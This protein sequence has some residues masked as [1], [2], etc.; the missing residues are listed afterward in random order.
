M[1]SFQG[2]KRRDARYWL[3]LWL[4][5]KTGSDPKQLINIIFSLRNSVEFYLWTVCNR[6]PTSLRNQSQEERILKKNSLNQ[7]LVPLGLT[8]T[9]TVTLARNYHLDHQTVLTI[10]NKHLVLEAEMEGGRSHCCLRY[11]IHFT[12]DLFSSTKTTTVQVWTS[13]SLSNSKNVP[14]PQVPRAEGT[15]PHNR[16]RSAYG[17]STGLNT[18]QAT[19]C[20]ELHFHAAQSDPGESESDW[21]VWFHDSY[22]T[23][24]SLANHQE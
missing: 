12:C 5:A 10:Y 6:L 24:C 21:R 2:I 14:D 4:K 23:V 1:A 11:G 7:P 8:G 3:G 19:L 9:A 20:R 13:T 18:R 16:A 15:S 22:S 17:E